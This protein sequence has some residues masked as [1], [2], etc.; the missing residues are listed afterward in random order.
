MENQQDLQSMG[1]AHFLSQTSGIGLVPAILLVIMSVATW[2]WIVLKGVQIWRIRKATQQFLSAFWACRHLKQ[3]EENLVTQEK[4]EPCAALFA[5]G[6]HA[7]RQLQLRDQGMLE[8]GSS[9]EFVLRTLRRSIT[10]TTLKLE[11]GLTMLA[12]VGSAAP[13]VGLFGTVWGIYNALIGISMAGQ[14]T[15]D[16]VAGPVGEAL[17]MTA[18]G[19]AVALPAVLAYNAFVRMNRV[20]LAE[21]DGF[22]HDVYALLV[23]GQTQIQSKPKAVATS[24]YVNTLQAGEA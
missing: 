22:A 9:E 17:I 16:K 24:A 20:Y 5:S 23:T 12:S 2:Y 19:L 15:L 1:I 11:S 7:C 18:F 14:S 6:L 3:V 8:M 21:L 10:Q 4:Q 13:F